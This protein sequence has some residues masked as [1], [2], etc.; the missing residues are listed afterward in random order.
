ML[1]MLQ[2]WPVA[3]YLVAS[4]ENMSTSRRRPSTTS[5]SRALVVSSSFL[6]EV[7]VLGLITILLVAV[8]PAPVDAF[9]ISPRGLSSQS[10]PCKSARVHGGL[11]VAA[12]H[13]NALRVPALPL[14]SSA[15]LVD[16]DD[17]DDN[18]DDD[19]DDNDEAGSFDPA[20]AELTESE[21]AA[22]A[23]DLVRLA[24][25]GSG[26]VELPDEISQSFLQY[27]LS[28][29]LGR[30]LPDAR[31]G[32]K[33]VHRRILYAMSGLGLNPGS[34]HRKC[35]RVVGEASPL[36]ILFFSACLFGRYVILSSHQYFFA[37][38]ISSTRTIF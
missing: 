25:G 38:S 7:L 2:C 17:D 22:A 5:T 26:S 8:P 12:N 28:I 13:A 31:D 21:L 36:R 9:S 33:P 30:A 29:I 16:D 4:I 24:G 14:F 23:N 1:Q 6:L 11:L 18:N 15:S 20:A 3:S 34:S 27:A 10:W 19:D 32:L 37:I 35:A